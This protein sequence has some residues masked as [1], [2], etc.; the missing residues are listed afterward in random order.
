MKRPTDLRLKKKVVIPVLILLGLLVGY[1]IYRN[2]TY[3]QGKARSAEMTKQAYQILNSNAGEKVVLRV[4]HTDITYGQ[5]MCKA[6]IIQAYSPGK[7][8]VGDTDNIKDAFIDLS[9]NIVEAYEV[10]KWMA[11]DKSVSI[12]PENDGQIIA[13][14]QQVLESQRNAKDSGA[15]GVA[16]VMYNHINDDLNYYKNKWLVYLW[17]NHFSK[18]SLS[19]GISSN[20]SQ[21]EKDATQE[22]QEEIKKLFANCKADCKVEHIAKGY[23]YLNET[24]IKNLN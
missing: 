23:N 17:I 7:N 14:Q 24:L 6:K 22:K 21:K 2:I 8:T 15:A 12:T 9:M 3:S 11:Q 1:F 10:K 16:S 4:N 5:L 18:S 13:S 20:D 19:V